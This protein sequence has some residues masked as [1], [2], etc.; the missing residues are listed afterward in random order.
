MSSQGIQTDRGE[1]T[2]KD[3]EAVNEEDELQLAGSK[4]V[5]QLLQRQGTMPSNLLKH[6]NVKRVI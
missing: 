2:N 6:P 4:S 3:L 1:N 5:G